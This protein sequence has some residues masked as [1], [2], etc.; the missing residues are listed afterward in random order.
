[1]FIASLFIIAKTWKQPEDKTWKQSSRDEWISKIWYIHTNNETLFLFTK[2]G[3]I[4]ICHNMDESLGCYAKCD[5]SHKTQTCVIP[6]VGG[7]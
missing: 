3:N 7:T 6:V 2:E 4:D 1:M 5:D